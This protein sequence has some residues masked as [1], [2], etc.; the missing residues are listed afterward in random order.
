MNVVGIKLEYIW[1]CKNCGPKTENEIYRRKKH[2]Y[3]ICRECVRQRNKRRKK[4][5]SDDVSREAVKNSRLKSKLEAL[6]TYSPNLECS[7]CHESMIEFL[8]IDHING[9]GLK[10]RKE[11]KYGSHNIF[12]WLKKN[13]YPPG[14][15]VLCHN[16]NFKYGVKTQDSFYKIGNETRRIRHRKNRLLKKIEIFN[17]YGGKC[18][19]CGTKDMTILCIDHIN[20]DGATHRKTTGLSS[21]VQF[22]YWLARNNFPGDFQILCF[23]CN[24]AKS[25][26]GSCPHTKFLSQYPLV[27]SKT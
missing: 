11:I 1:N 20:G 9:G 12:T 7:I 16:C 4:R 21:G 2:K 27:A 5:E 22:Y 10:H 3:I 26:Y 15:R 18:V 8:A 17:A 14:F 6:R 24:M 23:N 25:S 19:C 13:S